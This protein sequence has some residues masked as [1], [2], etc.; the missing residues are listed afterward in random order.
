MEK[1][2]YSPQEIQDILGI[3]RN[4]TYKLIK[5]KKFPV[6][7]IGHKIVIPIKTFEQWMYQ[8]MEQ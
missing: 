8:Q 3:G 4:S 2:V 6:I 7:N 5:E 1:Q